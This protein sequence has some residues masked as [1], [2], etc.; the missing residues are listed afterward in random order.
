MAGWYLWDKLRE[1]YNLSLKTPQNLSLCRTSI[2]NITQHTDFDK[3]ES[4][5]TKLDLRDKPAHIW[6]CDETGLTCVIKYG[7]T[8][9]HVGRKY[10]YKQSSDDRGVT[11]TLLC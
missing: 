11:T 9:C 5:L 8:V 2:V 4:L 10:I 3:V 7:K 6:N 1:R